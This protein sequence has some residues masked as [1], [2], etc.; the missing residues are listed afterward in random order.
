MGV[1]ASSS[2]TKF[3]GSRCFFHEDLEE[4][5]S[6]KGELMIGP[7][8]VEV[9]DGEEVRENSNEDMVVT[10]VNNAEDVEEEEIRV[11]KKEVELLR[12][13]KENKQF[14][15]GLAGAGGGKY[16]C[17]APGHFS[18]YEATWRDCIAGAISE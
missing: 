15:E 17:I 6:N 2:V 4:V 8:G 12:R 9:V 18:E 5:S 1:G 10:N 13:D 11:K 16:L 7:N 3:K 14:E